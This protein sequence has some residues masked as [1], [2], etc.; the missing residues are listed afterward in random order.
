MAAANC[1]GVI[2][3]WWARTVSSKSTRGFHRPPTG[4]I[5]TPPESKRTARRSS[6]EEGRVVITRPV[7]Y[8]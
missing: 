8:W 3:G 6:G 2:E 4:R 5:S 1:S 7:K